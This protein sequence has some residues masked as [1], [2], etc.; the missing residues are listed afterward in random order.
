MKSTF[1]SI[2]LP[3][4]FGEFASKRYCETKTALYFIKQYKLLFTKAGKV[5]IY[6]A[7]VVGII[8]IFCKCSFNTLQHTFFIAVFTFY[9][10]LHTRTHS[11]SL[12]LQ[13][14]HITNHLD[15]NENTLVR[16]LLYVLYLYYY[17]FNVSCYVLLLLVSTKY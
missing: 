11:V 12:R 4:C 3:R 9:Y 8:D 13:W 15:W 2:T 16:T 6:E 14:K 17:N 1:C 5:F 7:I 10:T